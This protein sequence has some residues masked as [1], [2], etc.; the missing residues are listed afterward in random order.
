M[1]RQKVKPIKT[2]F[3]SKFGYLNQQLSSQEIYFY[4]GRGDLMRSDDITTEA[5]SAKVRDSGNQELF[6]ALTTGD[7]LL[8][9]GIQPGV[10]TATDE[11]T[12]S[13][14]ESVMVDSAK[15]EKSKAK[16]EKKEKTEK[17][18]PKSLEEPPGLLNLN[19]PPV[20]NMLQDLQ[21]LHEETS[22]VI[23]FNYN[24]VSN[25]EVHFVSPSPLQ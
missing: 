3:S 21:G 2:S 12:K 22:T 5:V 24:F 11:G 8:T 17:V 1:K 10:R 23:R 9:G 15:V 25:L 16:K 20:R 13:L 18:E 4:V 14:L 6:E 7:G 19:W